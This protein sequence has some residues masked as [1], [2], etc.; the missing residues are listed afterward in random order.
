MISFE[1]VSK[2]YGAQIVLDSVGIQSNPGERVGVVGPNGAG[3]STLIDMI[4]GEM[5]RDSGRVTIPRNSRIGYLRQQLDNSE[6]GRDILSYAEAAVPD[7]RRV[8][9]ELDALEHGFAEGSVTDREAPS[10]SR[11]CSKR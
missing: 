7:L 5:S 9:E 11:V 2:R 3:K 1:N 6:A 8:E 4:A 10:I